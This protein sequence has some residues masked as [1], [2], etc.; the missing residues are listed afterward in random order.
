MQIKYLYIL[1]LAL[2]T[3]S[4]MPLGPDSEAASEASPEASI[5]PTSKLSPPWIGK[6][7]M[8]MPLDTRPTSAALSR[9]PGISNPTTDSM[10]LISSTYET[11]TG[12][13]HINGTRISRSLPT[14]SYN[15]TTS[16]ISAPTTT[17]GLPSQEAGTLVAPSLE[18]LGLRETDDPLSPKREIESSVFYTPWEV[19]CPSLE[20]LLEMNPN[21]KSYRKISSFQRPDITKSKDP[22]VVARRYLRKCE[23]CICDQ[24]EGTMMPNPEIPQDITEAYKKAIE[25]GLNQVWCDSW[26][27]V[28]KC[29]LWFDCICSTTMLQPG[30]KPGN[31]ISSYQRAL[32]KIPFS[33]KQQ[34][35]GYTWE[36]AP[37]FSMSWKSLGSA[38]DAPPSTNNRELVPG[39]KE[40]Y[41]VEGRDQG[42]SWDWPG[43]RTLLGDFGLNLASRFSKNF[44]RDTER[45]DEAQEASH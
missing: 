20:G 45:L 42:N 3:A 29:R 13:S 40:P 28:D 18:E 15:K 5:S 35:P 16:I 21:P 41:Y 44:K 39:T 32:D 10:L 19:V 12:M 7:N 26:F 4:S 25:K 36:P 38:P 30:V 1:S 2:C 9:T 8:S 33:V 37:R 23:N 11:A 24:I 43:M 6:L 17:K 31:S 34:Y 22:R 14:G 27:M